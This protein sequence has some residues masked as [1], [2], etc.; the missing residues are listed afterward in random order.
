MVK[1]I[2]ST[3]VAVS[4]V[5]SLANA[6]PSGPRAP[7]YETSDVVKAVGYDRRDCQYRLES[8]AS[9]RESDLLRSC[10]SQAQGARCQ[11]VARNFMGGGYIYPTA[12]DY[13]VEDYKIDANSC[14][15]RAASYAEREAVERCQKE[16]AVRCQITRRGYADHREERRRRYGLFGPKE[17]FQVCRGSAEAAPESRFREQCSMR[18]SVASY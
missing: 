5:A 9:R 10:Q 16:Y 3:V 8:E 15:N 4:S 12:G 11:V 2:L 1:W 6:A 13:T 14:R 17:N 18:I 7:R